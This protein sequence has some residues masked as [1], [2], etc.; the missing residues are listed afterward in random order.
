VRS[1]QPSRRVVVIAVTAVLAVAT[2]LLLPASIN[3]LQRRTIAIFLVAAI[4]WATEV[5]PLFATSLLVIGME[6]LFLASK[7]G[8]ADTLPTIATMPVKELSYT[9]FLQSFGSSIVILFFGGFMI[10]AAMTKHGLDRAIAA[11][12]L[13]PVSHSPLML[14]IAVVGISAFFS[15]WMSNTATAAMMLAIMLPV[16]KSVDENEPYLMALILAVPFGANIGGIGTPIGSPPNAVAFGV[17]NSQ[18]A[19]TGISMT[20][21]DWMMMAV[22]LEIVLLAV[23][24]I[25]LYVA[26]R[27]SKGLMLKAIETAPQLTG[28]AM[29]TLGILCV[30]I[31]LWLTGE[32]TG[33]KDAGV[34]LLAAAALC[35]FGLLDHKDVNKLDW[36]ILILMWGGLSLGDAIAQTGT[37]DLVQQINFAAIPGGAWA[38]ASIFVIVAVGLS[39]FMSNTAAANLIVPI[40]MA[41]AVGTK[42][43]PLELA[44]MTGLA[45]SFAMALPV[46][47]PPNALAFATGRVSARAMLLSGGLISIIATVTLLA[48]HRLLMP[49][50][51]GW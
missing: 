31:V 11:K 32:W 2:Y 3:E 16:F 26:F 12:L 18:S 50:L 1:P 28:K 27:P 48:G 35:T 34:A 20:F 36:N 40:A 33:L 42:E 5:L 14:L 15:M 25:V 24:V 49:F 37:A 29:V 23:V 45:C 4:F 38:V 41:L 8:L 6:V 9:L 51:L 30:A 39:T 43:T 46:S 47:T 7:G 13:R 44:L 21:L 22:P 17:I 19:S 10:S